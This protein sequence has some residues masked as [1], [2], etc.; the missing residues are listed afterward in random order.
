MIGLIKK[1]VLLMQ[2]YLKNL[3]LITAIFAG[4]SLFNEN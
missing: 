3:L 4:L 2:S 1:D